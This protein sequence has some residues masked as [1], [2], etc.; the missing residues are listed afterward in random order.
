M[1]TQTPFPARPGRRAVLAGLAGSAAAL[2][3]PRLARAQGLSRPDV[4]IGWTPWADAEATTKLV[5]RILRERKGL[6]VELALADIDAQF[7]TVAS[8]DIDMML[9]SWEPGLHASYLR[10]HGG[11]LA[12]LGALYE[13]SIGLAVPE[14][15]GPDRIA[16]IADLARPDLAEALGSTIT[17]IDPGAGLM[18]V[19]R[20]AIEIYG[21]SGY[22]LSEGTGPTM[23]RAVARA[24]RR[25]AP[26]VVTAWR[27]HAKF[28]LYG[29][30]YLDD[31]KGVFAARSTIT[32]RANAD[33]AAR[34][35][36]LVAVIDRISLPT[37]ALEG[38]MAQARTDGIDAAI[39]AWMADNASTI[40][41]WL[42]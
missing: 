18:S 33:F 31:P 9:M 39:E 12:N 21:L 4:I 30:R 16:S 17:G 26:I 2:A 20:E 32:A 34:N 11:E 10:R 37:P 5:A 28:A 23:V 24:A 3:A 6:D 15:V 25:E 19:T 22:T 1:T 29:M 13:G 36:D 40:D 8:G 14:W 27:P 41:A 38:I 42:G 7:R 35:P